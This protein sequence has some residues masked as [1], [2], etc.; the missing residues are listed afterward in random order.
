MKIVQPSVEILSC[1]AAEDVYS[2]IETAGRICYKSESMI[3]A[4]SAPKFC[5]KIVRSGHDSVIEHSSI[6][7]KFVCDRGVS[8]E[9][10]R[11]RLCSFS[12]ESTRY[13]NYT[14]DRFGNEIAV[15][16]PRFFCEDSIEFDLWEQSCLN[17][18]RAYLNLIERGVAPEWARS[19][20]PT[21]LK[22]EIIVTANIREW[23]HILKLR[24][25]P[26][27][28]P[29]I[30]E[31][32]LM[33]EDSL[34]ERLPVFFKKDPPVWHLSKIRECPYYSDGNWKVCR[35]AVS[36]KTEDRCFFRTAYGA[37][38]FWH[39]EECNCGALMAWDG[40][41]FVCGGCG[42]KRFWG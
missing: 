37:C 41:Q 42:N 40:R 29:Q 15:I 5:E 39:E 24:T 9:L 19:V 1:P 21:C 20:L 7:V 17:A 26:Q 18:E 4:T 12:Q 36:D 10:V 3:T 33:L 13:A 32:M 23:K 8:H 27:A 25:A 22:T 14:K 38:S 31:L 30:R 34:S 6:S 28:H 35:D 2:L 11:H 16:K